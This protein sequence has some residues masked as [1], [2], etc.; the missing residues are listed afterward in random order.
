MRQETKNELHPE[1]KEE[2]EFAQ[3]QFSPAKGVRTEGKKEGKKRD[4]PRE[5]RC[6]C[7]GK[8]DT[9]SV[10][11][12]AAKEEGGRRKEEKDKRKNECVQSIQ[13]RRHEEAE[14]RKA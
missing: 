11:I 8:D 9:P 4:G 3:G 7:E 12:Q 10:H 2:T 1:P 14:D 5:Q 13:S 6:Q